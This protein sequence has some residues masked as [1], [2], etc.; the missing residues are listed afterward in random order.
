MT[1]V[2]ITGVFLCALLFSAAS[3]SA[4]PQAGTA[5]PQAGTAQA[6]A[7]TAQPPSAVDGTVPLA[8]PTWETTLGYQW[9]RVPDQT[10]PFGLNVDGSYNFSA[11]VGLV[12]EVGWARDSED[13]VTF[14]AWNLGIGPRFTARPD[15]PVWPFAQVLVGGVHARASFDDDSASATRFMIQPG[16]GVYVNAGDGWGLVGQADYR[17]VFLDEDED[18]DT[19]EN[20][21]RLFIGLRLL[22]D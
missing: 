18:G 3:A 11:N 1:H 12:G 4:Q 7:G 15:G 2:R 19:G 20:D 5:Q 13:D 8:Y 10:F 6:P 16:A 14:N 9:L 21:L 17:R 22:L